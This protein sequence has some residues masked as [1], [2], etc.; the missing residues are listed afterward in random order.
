MGGEN[1]TINTIIR[2][3]PVKTSAIKLLT[4]LTIC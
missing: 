4:N 3:I 2:D 1:D